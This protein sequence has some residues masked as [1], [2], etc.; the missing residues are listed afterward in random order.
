MNKQLDK[1]RNK[2][3]KLRKGIILC[4]FFLFP[5][6]FYYFSP[7]LIIDATIR[8]II[9]GSFIFFVLLFVSSLF[10]GRAYCGWVCPA[11]GCQEAIFLASNKKITKGDFIK[12][13]IWIPWISTIAILAIRNRGYDK[14]DFFYRT[15]F[16]LS[17]ESVNSLIVYLSILS[18]IAIPALIFGKRSFCHHICWMAPF[19][20][21]GR[22]ARNTIKLPSL[23]LALNNENCSHCHKCTN[24]C[25][26][27]LPVELMVQEDKLENSECILCGTCIDVCKNKRIRYAFSKIA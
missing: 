11:A 5:A 13:I 17:I 23:Q 3:Q 15:K 10:L 26:M 9:N 2:R 24:N 14:F 6:V 21:I 19:L 4:S 7:Y 18:L 25:P 20:I 27:S 1:K 22:K 8:G 16:G 12:W